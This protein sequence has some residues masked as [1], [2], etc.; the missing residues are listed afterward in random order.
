M[1]VELGKYG[2]W[3]R[4]TEASPA[5]AGLAE[6]FGYGAFWVGGSPTGD[7]E[8]IEKILEGTERIAVATGIVNMWKD[9]ATTVAASYLR[10]A[11]RY[12]DRFLLGVG[13]GHPEAT[14]EYKKPIDKINEYLDEL[15]RAGVPKDGM[16]LAALGP[17]ALRIAAER[18]LGAHPYITTPR[19][20]TLA[21]E[22]MGAGPV[23]APEQKVMLTTDADEAREVVRANAKR[24]LQLTNYHRSFLRE[25]WSEEDLADGGSDE[26]IDLL[27]LH[28]EASQVAAGI[29]AHLEAGADHVGIQALGDD[30]TAQLATLAGVLF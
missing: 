18:T 29:N 22:V 17:V 5:F 4:A 10:I 13:V 23:I 2:V 1:T 11:E 25:G 19:H 16:M 27:G 28:G 12:A 21:R 15:D 26:L 30:P 3:T 14:A 7:L 20:T 8:A 6:E 9:D 24:Y